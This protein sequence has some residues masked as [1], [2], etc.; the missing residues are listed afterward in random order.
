MKKFIFTICVALGVSAFIGC[1]FGETA[2]NNV[3]SD[4]VVIDSIEEV[5]DSVALDSIICPD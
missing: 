2:Q 1:Q 4:S 5:I 3:E